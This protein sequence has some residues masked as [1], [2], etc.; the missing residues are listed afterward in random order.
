M[1]DS[2]LHNFEAA[3]RATLAFLHKRLGLDLWMV[4]RTEGDDWIVLQAEDHGYG[5][6]P[7]TVFRWADSFCSE[8]VKGNGPCIAPRSDA[9]PAYAA[10]PIG[11]QVKIGAY[12]GVPLVREGGGLFGTLCAIHPS[13]KPDSIA[14]E[15]ELVELLGAMLSNIL[16]GELRASEEARRSERLQAEA[17]TDAM[18]NLYNRRGWDQLLASEE[19]RCLRFG[20]SAAV[21]IVDLNG[22][23]H[24]NDSQGHAAGDALIVRAAAALRKAARSLDVI[25]RLGGDEFGILSAEC[26]RAGGNALL[27]RIRDA[28]SSEGVHAAIGLAIRD[29]ATGLKGACDSAD[30]LMYVEKHSQ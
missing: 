7:G 6:Q 26:D 10:A 3:A 2:S 25:A 22:L 11:R 27:A 17:M 28:L 24:V 12:V 8:M 14:H 20:H 13:P 9:I 15:Q 16:N 29:Q 5:V 23:K 30:R 21:L 18:T 1:N 19:E 4:T